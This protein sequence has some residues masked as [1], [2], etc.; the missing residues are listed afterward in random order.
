MNIQLVESEDGSHTLYLPDL[1]ETYHS[2][3]GAIQETRHVFIEAGL[4]HV[5]EEG[6]LTI[7]EVGF[8]TGLNVL[9]TWLAAE[10]REWPVHVHTLEPFPLPDDIINKLNYVQRIPGQQGA[11]YF[12]QIHAAEW[13]RT[14]HLSSCFSLYKEQNTLQAFK[15]KDDIDLVYYDAF[16]PNKQPELWELETIKK[17]VT[18]LKKGGVLVSYCASGQF[19]RNLEALGMEVIALPGPPGKKEMTRAVK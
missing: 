5:D 10:N 14:V 7:L 12:Q 9:L 8:G 15:A 19:K 2:L 6:P 4:Q 17:A 3:H 11:E 18:P 16:A 13:G 1:K